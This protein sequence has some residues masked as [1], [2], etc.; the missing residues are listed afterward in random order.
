M[1]GNRTH[2]H[3]LR[4]FEYGED[5]QGRREA[6]PASTVPPSPDSTRPTDNP[7]GI[8]RGGMSQETRGQ[9]K[10]NEPG[11]SGHKPQKHTSEQEKH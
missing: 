1:P 9:N 11:Q 5:S 4:Q 10:H 2:E 3:Q 7:S 8:S 6:D